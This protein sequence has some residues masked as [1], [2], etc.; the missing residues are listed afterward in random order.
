MSATEIDEG[1]LEA[2]M[3]QA[4]TDVGAVISAPLVIR[5]EMRNQ[6]AGG[7]VTYEPDSDRYTLPDEQALALANEESPF[8][9]LG[10]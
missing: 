8:Y 7:Y 4:V 3:G 6:A 10:I 2:F 5:G 1:K 9:I